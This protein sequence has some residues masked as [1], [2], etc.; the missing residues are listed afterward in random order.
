MS[1]LVSD[2]DNTESTFDNLYETFYF[3]TFSRACCEKLMWS[4]LEEGRSTTR[5]VTITVGNERAQIF[6]RRR[7]R[8]EDQSRAVYSTS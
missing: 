2:G 4:E 1:H 6:V 7:E 8:S 5:D 3:H